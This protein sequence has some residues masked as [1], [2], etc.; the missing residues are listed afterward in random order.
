MRPSLEELQT[1]PW[2]Y[3]GYQGFSEWMAS[4]DDFFIIRRFGSLAARVILSLQW[5]IT[6]LENE[7][8]RLDSARGLEANDDLDNGSF[9]KDD[10]KRRCCICSICQALEEYC[11][12]DRRHRFSDGRIQMSSLSLAD[13]N[14]KY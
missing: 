4:D 7:L 1:K 8:C 3:I 2:K 9:E 13:L 10:D 5:R 6:K 14:A 12:Q 11:E